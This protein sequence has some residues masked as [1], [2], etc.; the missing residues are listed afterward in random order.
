MDK[1][2]NEAM[3]EVGKDGAYHWGEIKRITAELDV[4]CDS[5]KVQLDEVNANPFFPNF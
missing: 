2:M 5:L 1:E 3:Q 4:L